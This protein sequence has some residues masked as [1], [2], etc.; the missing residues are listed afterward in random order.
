MIKA[1]I[2]DFGGVLAEEGFKEGLMAI[3]RDNGLN[4]ESFFKLAE[5]LV[6]Q[7][8]YVTGK[9]HESDYWNALREKIGI[10]KSDEELRKEIL[11]RFV[12]RSE[13]LRIVEKLRSSGYVVA[14]LSDQTN[15]L[16]D[17]NKRTP[18][19]HHFDFVYN[20]FSLKKS[21]RDPSLFSDICSAMGFSPDEV[22]FVDD[23]LEN[24]RNAS[25][26][27]LKT[28]HFTSIEE[29]QKEVAEFM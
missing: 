10:I 7:T 21:K 19:Y 9:S 4:G 12:L 14:I 22:L 27:G 15:W 24:I 28:I 17:I 3:G 18:F 6:Y 1:V 23:H 29:F 20:S 16:D 13:M 25:D 5:E 2:F 26:K 11:K 8:G